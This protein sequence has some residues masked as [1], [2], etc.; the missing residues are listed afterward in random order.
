MKKILAIGGVS[1]S[2]K[3][4]LRDSL[5]KAFPDKYYKVEQAT[6]RK[7]REGED[8]NTYKF[9]SKE[10][11]DKIKDSLFGKTE[12]NGNFYGSFLNM[13]DDDD[14]IGIIIL[15]KSGIEDFRIQIKENNLFKVL[16]LAIDK[17]IDDI[18]FR[19]E[20]RDENYLLKEKEIVQECDIV[21][22]LRDKRYV[23]IEEVDEL[24]NLYLLKLQ[25]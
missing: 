15:N 8:P 12:V 16:F 3:T 1:G 4:Y 23:T 17:P 22:N 5:V 6:T 20:G 9:M 24:A 18:E 7:I 21:I 10:E 25:I 11:F 2:G 13:E 19:R 14:R